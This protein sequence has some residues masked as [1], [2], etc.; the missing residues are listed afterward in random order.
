[1][2]LIL[3]AEINKRRSESFEK[4]HHI[5]TSTIEQLVGPSTRCDSGFNSTGERHSCDSLMLGKLLKNASS[6]KLYPVML[7]DHR[8]T[9]LFRFC[10]TVEELKSE[11]LCEVKLNS[12][13]QEAPSAHGLNAEIYNAVQ[14]IWREIKGL[15]LSDY[16]KL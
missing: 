15:S 16:K 10:T 4:V 11:S 6:A 13:R 3:P 12:R 2:K 5:V 7:P 14:V 9:S 8:N 1:M